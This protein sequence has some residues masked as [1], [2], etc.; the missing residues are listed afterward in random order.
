MARDLQI[1]GIDHP[2]QLIGKDGHQ[3]YDELCRRTDKR[4]DSCV[5]DVF[6]SA[7]DFMNGG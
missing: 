6:L 3:L 4:H 7:A 2:Q 5:I 1:L